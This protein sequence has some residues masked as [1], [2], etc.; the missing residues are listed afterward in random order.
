M[1]EQTSSY[2]H[3]ASIVKE[4]TKILYKPLNIIACCTKHVSLHLGGEE[5]IP[6]SKFNNES[7]D[8]QQQQY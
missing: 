2:K 6:S 5:K 4:I 7:G 3:F 1:M 8:A